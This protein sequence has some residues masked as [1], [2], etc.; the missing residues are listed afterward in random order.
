MRNSFTGLVRVNEYFK[1][2]KHEQ[3]KGW[4]MLCFFLIIVDMFVIYWYFDLKKL[5]IAFLIVFM[6][7]TAY[8][9]ILEQKFIKETR[10]TKKKKADKGLYETLQIAIPKKE[11]FW[12]DKAY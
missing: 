4:K 1:N 2:L 8:I 9:L 6:S 10:K 11:D 7:F 12:D 5:G 3:V